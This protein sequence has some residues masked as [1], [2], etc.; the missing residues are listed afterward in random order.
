MVVL[1]EGAVGF[2]SDRAR[3]PVRVAGAWPAPF[4]IRGWRDRIRRTAGTWPRLGKR[5]I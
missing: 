3:T 5:G 2:S 4:W 1:A